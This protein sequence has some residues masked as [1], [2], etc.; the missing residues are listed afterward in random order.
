M[1]GALLTNIISFPGFGIEGFELDPV[2]FRI[3]LFWTDGKTH[4]IMWYGIIITLA[5][6]VG[7]MVAYR[8]AKFEGINGDHVFDLAIY[9]II[10]AIVGARLYYV[11]MKP[12]TFKSFYDVIAIW[13]GGLAIYGG[14]IAGAA[15]I[16]V[17]SKVKKIKTAKLLD[18]A[19][20]GLIIGQA[21][22]RWGNFFNA[23]AYGTVT[24]LPWRMGIVKD[25]I[26]VMQFYHPTFLYESLW[27]ILGFIL[28]M[29]FYKK[30]KYD[31]A[32]TLWYLVWYGFGRFFIE[33]LRTDSLY[34]L[35]G[36]L[37]QTVRV[38]Q[39]VAALCVVGGV[40]LMIICGIRAKRAKQDAAE[41]A[42]VYS[43]NTE[44]ADTPAY[45]ASEPE[46]KTEDTETNEE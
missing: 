7:F 42:P 45:E 43:D 41:Y 28:I 13:N 40:I 21:I 6:I 5:M 29:S 12:E 46:A 8:K 17:F 32:P 3:P 22:G 25:G 30:K 16:F 39:L 2:A 31:G 23:E 14:V 9:L 27:N 18:I 24:D 26:G 11:I 15:T 10:A 1:I 37:G 4:P 20:P 33:G 35:E 19:V 44:E 34:L 38:S 36:V